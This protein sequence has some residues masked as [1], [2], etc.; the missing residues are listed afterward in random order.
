M[1]SERQSS[2]PASICGKCGAALGDGTRD[3]LCTACLLGAALS[4]FA[5]EE[6]ERTASANLLARRQFAG[7]ELLDEI[8]RGGM[9]I[10]FRARQRRPDRPVALK[11]IAA[12]ELASPR[13]VQRF[14]A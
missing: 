1:P 11:V 14:Q 6:E 3:G 8:A 5:E 9:G 12:G 7:Y 4:T 10:V 2:E 13:M